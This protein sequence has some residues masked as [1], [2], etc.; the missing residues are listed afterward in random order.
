M[1]FASKIR[2]NFRHICAMRAFPFFC[3]AFF[4][5]SLGDLPAE[6]LPAMRP[7]L[8]GNGK[9]SWINLMD[10]ERLMKRGQTDAIVRFTCSI[11]SSGQG[12][13]MVTYRG[14]ANARPLAEEAI[15]K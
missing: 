14:S 6:Q 13:N 8:L 12:Y 2:L 5:I 15:D 11:Y 3:G 7:A 1:V 4:L 10:A 9:G